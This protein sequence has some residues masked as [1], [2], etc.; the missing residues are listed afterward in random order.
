M[1]KRIGFIGLGIMGKPMC[2]NLIKAGFP[3]TVYN[4]SRAA[5]EV[6]A[7]YG[8]APAKSSKEV[9]EKSDVVIT[10]VT[11]SPDVEGVVLGRNGVIEGA[12]KGL[13]VIDMS[14]ISPQ[15]TRRIAADL[16][17]KGVDM[18]DAPVSGGEKGAIEGTLS[19]MVGGPKEVFE[20]CLPILK[21]LG[22][23]IV[24]IGDHGAGQMT[25]LCN[26]IVGSLT[27]L[28]TCEGLLLASKAGL[29]LGKMIEAVGAGAAGSWMMSNLAP[30]ITKRDLEPGFM[31]KLMQKDL[32]IALSAAA[33]LN[34]PLP[35]TGLVHQL[36]RSV[37]AD[38]KGDKGIQA[39]V[40]ALEKLAGFEVRG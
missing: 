24:H 12:K 37:E 35:A 36:Y 8:A 38:G 32:R 11:D 25:K 1:A 21:A 23:N 2:R 40:T 33:E 10:I 34:L 17:S 4:R 16:A 28:A 14:T 7:S 18:L 19:I 3:V 15:V 20:G 6:V 9:A 5:V 13:T 29:D 22:K 39:L 31:V 26:Q 30:K 27:L